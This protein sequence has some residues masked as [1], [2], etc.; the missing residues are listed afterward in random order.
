MLTH[1]EYDVLSGKDAEGKINSLELSSEDLS[2]AH[3]L[4]A[5]G[6]LGKMPD[7][8]RYYIMDKGADALSDYERDNQ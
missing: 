1:E 6:Y 2:I 8:L 3:K 7:G 5:K 4:W